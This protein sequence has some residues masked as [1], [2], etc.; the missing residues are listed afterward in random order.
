[1]KT[2]LYDKTEQVEPETKKILIPTLHFQYL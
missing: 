2:Y 1:M